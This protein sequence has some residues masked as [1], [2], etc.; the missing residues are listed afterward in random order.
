MLMTSSDPLI[1][2]MRKQKVKKNTLEFNE[3]VKFL[4]DMECDL[5]ED[6]SSQKEESNGVEDL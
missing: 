1:S 3:D 6:E 2:T 4:L 5:D